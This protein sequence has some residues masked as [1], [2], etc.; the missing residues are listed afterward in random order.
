MAHT[1]EVFNIYGETI[2]DAFI[3]YDYNSEVLCELIHLPTR[4]H[5]AI[6]PFLRKI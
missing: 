2:S 5:M 6:F 3:T 4:V 1:F